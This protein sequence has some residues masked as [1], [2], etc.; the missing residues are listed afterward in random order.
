M[1]G[2][3]SRLSESEKGKGVASSLSPSI[4]QSSGSKLLG[5]AARARRDISGDVA[6]LIVGRLDG[7][8]NIPNNLGKN[9]E[10]VGSDSDLLS[11]RVENNG[12]KAAP[13]PRD[14]SAD[15]KSAEV[16]WCRSIPFRLVGHLTTIGPLDTFG[17]D[18]PKVVTFSQQERGSFDRKRIRRQR[19]RIAKVDWASN[20]PC[21]ETKGRRMKLALMGQTSKAYP[22]YSDILRAQLGGENFTAATES[23]EHGGEMLDPKGGESN[24][25]ANE[26]V[27]EGS[28]DPVVDAHPSK[29]KKKKK[30]M[31][32][33]TEKAGAD[34]KNEVD[35]LLSGVG[36]A[37]TDRVPDGVP[38]GGSTDLVGKVVPLGTKRGRVID[39]DLPEPSGKKPCRS[40]DDLPLALKETSSLVERDLWPWGG[41]DPPFKKPLLAS[42]EHLSFRYNKDAPFASDPDSCAELV[43]RIRGGMHMMPQISEFPFPDGFRESARA[44]IEISSRPRQ[45]LRP[46]MRRLPNSRKMLDKAKGMVAGVAA[47]FANASRLLKRPRALKK[48]WRTPRKVA[49]LEVEK[50]DGWEN[51]EAIDRMRQTTVATYVATSCIETLAT[52]W[53]EKFRQYIADRDRREVKLLLH[54]QAFGALG[55]W[56][57]LEEFGSEHPV[58]ASSSSSG[59]LLKHTT[60]GVHAGRPLGSS[61]GISTQETLIERREPRLQI[62]REWRLQGDGVAA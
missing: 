56:S 25:A 38:A 5:V 20:L 7:A 14:G 57:A 24:L 62:Q 39:R 2:F 29:K 35:R 4:D 12:G 18:V 11:V 48:N 28:I 37:K 34:P 47:I 59:D 41:P 22:S 10:V 9:D 16:V 52:D 31:A 19:K 27:V 1:E 30:K 45:L 23:E 58:T 36:A 40:E 8:V 26:A 60:S 42:S 46:R 53:F 43:R 13:T 32:G 54:S 49:Q 55:R 15:L 33:S 51:E 3:R 50:A 6:D 21:G 61:L 17:R 44:D